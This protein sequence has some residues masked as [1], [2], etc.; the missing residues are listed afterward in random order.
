MSFL[1]K[2]RDSQRKK[3]PTSDNTSSIFYKQNTKAVRQLKK[4]PKSKF[5]KDTNVLLSLL[6]L[7]RMGWFTSSALKQGMERGPGKIVGAAFPPVFC[8]E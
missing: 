7:D 3:T 4:T 8:G 2:L 1:P 5:S 6:E